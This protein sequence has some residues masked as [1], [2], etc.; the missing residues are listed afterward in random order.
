MSFAKDDPIDPHAIV[1]GKVTFVGWAEDKLQAGSQ[2][3][4]FA[5]PT[6]ATQY[7]DQCHHPGF[8]VSHPL[9]GDTGSL[10]YFRNTASDG[11]SPMF[12]KIAPRDWVDATVITM[13]DIEAGRAV[14]VADLT[15]DELARAWNAYQRLNA[16]VPELIIKA[17]SGSQGDIRVGA[18]WQDG[19]WTIEISRALVTGHADDVQFDDLAEDYYFNVSIWT[20]QDISG[21]V[22]GKEMVLRFDRSGRQ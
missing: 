14:R 4:Q 3:T 1:R 6:A 8:G 2:D 16:V 5:R 10:P 13:E 7:C 19:R 18:T 9:K 20:T 22:R 12:I 21:D 15:P 17:P 11:S